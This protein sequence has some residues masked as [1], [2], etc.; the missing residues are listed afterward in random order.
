MSQLQREKC[1]TGWWAIGMSYL[2]TPGMTSNLRLANASTFNTLLHD[3]TWCYMMLHDVT[4]HYQLW[5]LWV[6]KFFRSKWQQL[7]AA[8]R[9]AAWYAW[10]NRSLRHW[11]GN[12]PP[13][14]KLGSP[15]LRT[16]RTPRTYQSLPNITKDYQTHQNKKGNLKRHV[17]ATWTPP[18]L[19]WR[20]RRPNLR[21]LLHYKLLRIS[22]LYIYYIHNVSHIHLASPY[23]HPI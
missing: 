16:Q 23:K 19:P 4:C 6:E 18:F 11:R 15:P 3:V 8:H 20:L 7:T 21:N 12:Q 13:G 17:N 9:I 22:M 14:L 1:V 10:T 5:V 2:C